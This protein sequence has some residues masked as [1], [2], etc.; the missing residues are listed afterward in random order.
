MSGL[1]DWADQGLQD[2][3][4]FWLQRKMVNGCEGRYKIMHDEKVG[5]KSIDLN[6]VLC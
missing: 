4:I 5:T 3:L 2:R 6:I 1:L